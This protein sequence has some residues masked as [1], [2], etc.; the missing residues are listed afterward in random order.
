[1]TF[2]HLLKYRAHAQTNTQTC[3]IFLFFIFF[4]GR[5]CLKELCLLP[6]FDANI[7]EHNIL[8]HSFP[9]NTNDTLRQY[10]LNESCDFF[11]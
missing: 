11:L 4:K 5:I 10:R 7:M 8:K 2:S 6:A 1:M 3:I 9:L